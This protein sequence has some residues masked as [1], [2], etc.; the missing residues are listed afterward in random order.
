MSDPVVADKYMMNGNKMLHHLDRVEAW[1]R[2]DHIAPIHIDAGLSKGYNTPKGSEKYFPREALLQYVRDCGDL[3]VRSMALI[4]EAEPLLNPH[5][6]EAIIEG[7]KAGVDMS[8]GTNGLMLDTGPLGEEALENLTWI[9]FN[10]SAATPKDYARING[11]NDFDL[12][13]EKIKFCVAIKK[14]KNLSLTVGLQMVLTPDNACQ[15]IPLAI[16][17][18]ELGVDYTVIK[19]CDDTITSAAD[20]LDTFQQF[21]DVLKGAETHTGKNYNVIVK[22]DKILNDSKR[23]YDQCLGAPFLLHSSGDGK[24]YTCANFFE[25]EK[26]EAYRLGDLVKHSFKELIESEHYWSV[27]NKVYNCINVHKEC[28][29]HCRTNSINDFLWEFKDVPAHVDFI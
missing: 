4:G 15:T 1:R 16:L 6:Y 17:G 7:K 26:E 3:G 28:Y 12:A 21:T 11:N 27:I 13:I 10:I 23:N 19:Q 22:W 25:G 9:R 20:R 5:V 24:L 29:S 18:K 14:K 8:M 2:G